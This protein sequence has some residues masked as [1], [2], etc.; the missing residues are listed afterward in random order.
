[1]PV[2]YPKDLIALAKQR[3]HQPATIAVGKDQ[4]WQ[5]T[6]DYAQQILLLQLIEASHD[7]DKADAA[8]AAQVAA[9]GPVTLTIPGMESPP[10]L[11]PT[12]A[13]GFTPDRPYKAPKPKG[14]RGRPRKQPAAK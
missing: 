10:G 7:R 14:K 12:S 5:G 2:H 3:K 11:L 13:D 1:M 9:A 4:C 6:A 8:H